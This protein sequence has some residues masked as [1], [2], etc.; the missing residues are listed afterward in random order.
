M[1]TAPPDQDSLAPVISGLSRSRRAWRF[2]RW[3]LIIGVPYATGWVS[4][5]LNTKLEVAELQRDN[6]AKAKQIADLRTSLDE[7]AQLIRLYNQELLPIKN[8]LQ[9]VGRAVVQA[10]HMALAYE[11]PSIRKRKIQAG[12]DI[13]GAYDRILADHRTSVTGAIENTAAEIAVP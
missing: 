5:R 11:Q 10:R 4:G 2:A 8:D 7:Q 3:L 13:G 12:K 6:L 9:N 1:T